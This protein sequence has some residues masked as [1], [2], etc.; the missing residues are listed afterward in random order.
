[1]CRSEAAGGAGAF[2][3]HLIQVQLAEEDYTG[4]FETAGDLGIC[5]RHSVFEDAC[6]SRSLDASGVDVVLECDGHAVEGPFGA[7]GFPFAVGFPRLLDRRLL[8]FRDKGVQWRVE[9]G[10]AGITEFGE[11]FCRD[12]AASE[13]DCGFGEA[14]AQGV[15]TRTG[16]GNAWVRADAGIGG[17]NTG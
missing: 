2:E 17:C 5:S 14:P 13:G 3:G 6:R 15:R 11:F 9:L 16:C 1:M 7:P 8:I 4:A 12:L 10:D